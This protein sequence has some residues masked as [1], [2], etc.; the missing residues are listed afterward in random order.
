MKH[1]GRFVLLVIL[2]AL[3]VAVVGA[4]NAPILRHEQ[5]TARGE[6]QKQK[7]PYAAPTVPSLPKYSARLVPL[8]KAGSIY[9]AENEP[10]RKLKIPPKKTRPKKRLSKKREEPPVVNKITVTPRKTV[11]KKPAKPRT[12]Q[13]PISKP[14]LS[15]TERDG[16]RP[17]LDVNYDEIGF[18]KYLDIIERVGRLYVLISTPDGLKLGPQVSLKDKALVPGGKM[19]V[20]D[21]ALDRPHL[22]SDPHIQERLMEVN[23]PEGASNESVVLLLTKPFDSVLWDAISATISQSGLV[24]GAVAQIKGAYVEGGRGV[25]LRL[26]QAVPKSGRGEVALNRKVR[27][28]L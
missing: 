11:T 12:Q 14:Q 19:D 9:V 17:I 1:K 18:E 22:V 6:A 13:S 7:T 25:F 4:F 24:L 28:T 8:Y 2:S 23:L 3:L 10:R 15:S 21:F 26:D 16:D 5:S 27:V 20:D